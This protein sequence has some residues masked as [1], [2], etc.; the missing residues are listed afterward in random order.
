[1]PLRH[2]LDVPLGQGG[3]P[4]TA[5]PGW[6]GWF[7][8]RILGGGGRSAEELVRDGLER[9]SYFIGPRFVT[10]RGPGWS[11]PGV[12]GEDEDAVRGDDDL[13]GRP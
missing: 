12:S 7:V 11:I 6:D 10:Y 9:Q 2:L 8:A 3:R 5:R 13:G 1:V 4:V